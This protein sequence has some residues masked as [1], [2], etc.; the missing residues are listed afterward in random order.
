[1][2]YRKF[3]Y[4][5]RFLASSEERPIHLKQDYGRYGNSNYMSIK[6]MPFLQYTSL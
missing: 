5:E 3:K 4:F 1:M 2:F 6:F